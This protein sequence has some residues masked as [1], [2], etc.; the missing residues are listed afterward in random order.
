MIEARRRAAT[1]AREWEAAEI[2]KA[3]ANK[4][5][6]AERD[7]K[8]ALVILDQML[9]ALPAEVR[10]QVGGFTRVADLK[11]N[12]ARFK[13][14]E[15][16]VTEIDRVLERHLREK[17]LTDLLE[18][19]KRSRP[20]A[21]VGER[22]RGKL[23]VNAHAWMTEAERIM[24]LSPAQLEAEEDA[25]EKRQASATL[26][27]EVVQ[28][29][30][31]QYD[32]VTDEASAREA[33]DQHAALLNLFG[34]LMHR[35][36]VGTDARG[37]DI[38]GPPIRSASEMF[39]ALEAAQEMDTTGRLGWFL[40][41]MRRRERRAMQR[42]LAIAD[43]GGLEN[44]ENRKEANRQNE[45]GL[46]RWARDYANGHFSF[47][48]FVSS[49]F[50]E[51]SATHQWADQTSLA[52]DLSYRDAMRAREQSLG[53]F[54]RSL[55]PRSSTRQ[56]QRN[57]EKLATSRPVVGAPAGSRERMSEL[58]AI[59]YRMLWMDEDTASRE[60]LEAHRYGQDMQDAMEA[61]LSD[62]AKAIRSWLVAQY[63][64]Q[65]DQINAVYRR[66]YGVNMPRVKNYA[67]RLVDHGGATTDMSMDPL[68][69]G[70]QL[71]AG[72]TKRRRLDTK[73][74]PRQMDALTAYWQNAHAVEY[75][76]HWAEGMSDFR[77]VFSHWQTQAA[78]KATNGD[79]SGVDLN[80]WVQILE[81]N[82]VQNA[83][84]QGQL[85][86]W[87]SSM[88][89]YAL[90]GKLGVLAKQAVAGYASAS[91][92]GIPEYLGAVQRIVRGEAS[93]TL[94]EIYRSDT[95][96]RRM[97]NVSPEV[98]IG[99]R[100]RGLTPLEGR[101]DALLQMVG[102][103]I[104][105]LDNAHLWLRE[106]IG[107][108]DA[109]FTTMS[110]AAAYDVAFREATAAG[111]VE[112]DARAAATARM[113]T[114]VADS[115]QPETV[116]DKSLSELRGGLVARLLMP[117]QS[118]NRQALGMTLLAVKQKRWQD[119]AQMAAIHWV[120]T[121]IIA[122]TIGSIMR[123]L[124][125]DDDLEDVWEWE[126]YARAMVIGP[127]TG[128]RYLGMAIEALAP[129]FGGFERRQAAVPMAEGIRLMRQAITG[130]FEFKSLTNTLSGVGLLIGG[131]AS[132]ASISAS[133]IKQVDGLA[134]T[135]TRTDA[136][137]EAEQAKRDKATLKEA[138]A[139][140]P[141]KP[142]KPQEQKDAEA[143]KRRAKEA[144]RAAAIRAA[145]EE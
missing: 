20:K 142:E 121:G 2:A 4:A 17:Y 130:D 118:A 137:R 116:R 138:A 125:S 100:G 58:D 63:D 71:M 33:V 101:L 26:T 136:E 14:F 37:N 46:E 8:R 64:A 123:S 6:S 77:A 22:D 10:S 61:M 13:Y 115:A 87:S 65:Y 62:E 134:D 133:I 75:W 114:V 5:A 76:T 82:G 108:M 44:A 94:A 144:A 59:H 53:G 60:W 16:K 49:L 50:G 24:R 132:W 70:R 79:Q 80:E 1:E 45:S 127:L 122:Q 15:R 112:A 78:V 9:M 83:N 104:Y 141:A 126:D 103:D 96:Q 91:Q 32:W 30:A 47:E 109:L 51:D 48:G 119:V 85:R 57:L 98:R 129:I 97:A 95:I 135:V 107:A 35:R 34:G 124:F 23:G 28:E 69:E 29:Y 105:A 102:T 139:A 89:D 66:M 128:A 72:F 88:A 12:D 43:A 18:L 73:S 55:W 7:S 86:K 74:P 111:L 42:G 131:R 117:F 140:A 41:I 143:A 27:D 67:P 84:G 92:L 54:L 56:R 52:A 11:T 68:Q 93:V 113:E 3:R 106:R 120:A 110:A 145:A 19:F 38:S 99:T 36:S 81:R 25:V 31:R 39:A 40:E 21:A 90:V